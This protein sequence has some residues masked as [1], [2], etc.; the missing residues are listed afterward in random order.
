MKPVA[1]GSMPDHKLFVYAACMALPG[2]PC[3]G[4]ALVAGACTVKALLV[5]GAAMPPVVLRMSTI[6]RKRAALALGARAS[7]THK[8]LSIALVG[9]CDGFCSTCDVI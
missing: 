2:C 3:T 7:H 1:T 8:K 6:I 9:G 4:C 5:A